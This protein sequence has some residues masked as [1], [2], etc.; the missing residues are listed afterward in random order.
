MIWLGRWVAALGAVRAEGASA[1][2]VPKVG[3][4]HLEW[5]SPVASALLALVSA[6]HGGRSGSCTWGL[7]THTRG[8]GP[9]CPR[10]VPPGSIRRRVAWVVSGL[11]GALLLPPHQQSLVVLNH[12]LNPFILEE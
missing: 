8:R 10:A 4:T 9:P 5:N 12:S 6:A 7:P 11:V 3:G 2:P 1:L